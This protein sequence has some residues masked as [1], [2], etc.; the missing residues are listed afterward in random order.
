MCS[1]LHILQTR[2]RSER[3]PEI[4]GRQRKDSDSD[5]LPCRGASPTAVMTDCWAKDSSTSTPLPGGRPTIPFGSL[6]LITATLLVS[7]FLCYTWSL[8]LLRVSGFLGPSWWV[9]LQ[10][11]FSRGWLWTA[12]LSPRTASLLETSPPALSPLPG[13]SDGNFGLEL[14]TD[15]YRW[16]SFAQ[17]TYCLPPHRAWKSGN[18]VW[19]TPGSPALGMVAW[20]NH[21]GPCSAAK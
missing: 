20:T 19:L 13:F 11:D 15:I 12:L 6:H 17:T 14:D 21:S 7:P 5:L 1:D 3:P 10:H 16:F 8:M 18:C 2:D 4:S 9:S